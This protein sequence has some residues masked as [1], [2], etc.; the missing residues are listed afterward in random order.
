MDNRFYKKA[1]E[2]CIKAYSV[3]KDLGTTE[4][5]LE[6]FDHEGQTWQ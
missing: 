4:Y 2:L 5:L 1:S 6:L 3:R